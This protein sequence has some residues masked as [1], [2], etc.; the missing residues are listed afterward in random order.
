MGNRREAKPADE[1][2]QDLDTGPLKIIDARTAAQ[3]QKKLS[4][5]RSTV[6]WSRVRRI[7]ISQQGAARRS[8]NQKV[9]DTIR[10][11]IQR[12]QASFVHRVDKTTPLQLVDDRGVDELFRSRRWIFVFELAVNDKLNR[13][14]G[15]FRHAR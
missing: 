6:P 4:P 5:A 2:K 7:S 11:N 8:R 12:H 1:L 15:W 3:Y 13:F 10:S 14:G 9:V